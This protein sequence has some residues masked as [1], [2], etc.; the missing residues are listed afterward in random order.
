V[1]KP[2]P[3]KSDPVSRLKE[4]ALAYADAADSDEAL[5]SAWTRL[6]HAAVAYSG[7]SERVYCDNGCGRW[8]QH[9]ISKGRPRRFC[10]VAC[11][12]Q[13]RRKSQALTKAME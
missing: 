3:A 5:N 10:S 2:G 9:Y 13:K 12:L 11:G 7:Q 8:W 4:A 6:S 1:S